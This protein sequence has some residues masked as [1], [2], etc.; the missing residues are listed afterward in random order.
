MKEKH[1]IKAI[2]QMKYQTCHWTGT[3]SEAGFHRFLTPGFVSQESSASHLGGFTAFTFHPKAAD[4]GMLP[5]NKD[6]AK[7]RDML[8]IKHSDDIVSYFA[9]KSFFVAS[10]PNDLKI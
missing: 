1:I 4:V 7:I 2:S 10:N 3:F 6:K 9:K 5:M 8:G